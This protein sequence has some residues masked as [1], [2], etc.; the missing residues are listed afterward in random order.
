[1]EQYA[2]RC[3]KKSPLVPLSLR[4]SVHC[5]SDENPELEK[6][7][8]PPRVPLVVGQMKP[9]TVQPRDVSR[10]GGGQAGLTGVK[11]NRNA[12]TEN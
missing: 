4:N 9:M 6:G 3:T 8:P 1:M 2:R 11:R 5:R 7:V 12:A 10:H